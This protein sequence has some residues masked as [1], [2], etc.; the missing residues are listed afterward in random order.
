LNAQQFIGKSGQKIHFQTKR[1]ANPPDKDDSPR[2]APLQRKPQVQ[3][4]QLPLQAGASELAALWGAEKRT[5][6]SSLILNPGLTKPGWVESSDRPLSGGGLIESMW[7][8]AEES[9]DPEGIVN[10]PSTTWRSSGGTKSVEIIENFN[11][12][13]QFKTWPQTM[14]SLSHV[15]ISSNNADMFESLESCHEIDLTRKGL[16][17]SNLERIRG[18]DS[19]ECPTGDRT[20][21]PIQGTQGQES[22]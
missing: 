1:A 20:I 4:R 14:K 22:T 7:K 5:A 8:K 19:R 15:G 10:L 12:R 9:V 21:M 11:D 6:E 18:C 17:C 16:T 2:L 3:A 13:S